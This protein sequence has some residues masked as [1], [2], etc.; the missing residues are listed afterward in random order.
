MKQLAN[1]SLSSLSAYHAVVIQD[2]GGGDSPELSGISAI[3]PQPDRQIRVYPFSV[4]SFYNVGLELGLV[5]SNAMVEW[6]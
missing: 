3:T 2:M 6:P 4:T 1:Q 5:D